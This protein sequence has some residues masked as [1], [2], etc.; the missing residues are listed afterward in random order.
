MKTE[1]E[2]KEIISELENRKKHT[3]SAID[4]NLYKLIINSL[5]WVL[6]D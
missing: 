3:T 1:Q 5:K 6:E 4:K 2:I